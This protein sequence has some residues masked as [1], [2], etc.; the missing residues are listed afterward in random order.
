MC[1]Q[2]DMLKL[3]PAWETLMSEGTYHPA[4][5]ERSVGGGFF[6]LFLGPPRLLRFFA[7]G[8][9]HHVLQV[10][11]AARGVTLEALMADHPAGKAAAKLYAGQGRA[12]G[13]QE[14][15]ALRQRIMALEAQAAGPAVRLSESP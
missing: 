8:Q 15:V 7:Q 1:P 3:P 6:G 14:K 9:G 10:S 4:G 2:A 11:D 12:K 13:P 5:R